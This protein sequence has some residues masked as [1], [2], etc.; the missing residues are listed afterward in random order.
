MQQ[1]DAGAA[2]GP[3]QAR[4]RRL[5]RIWF[6]GSTPPT[7]GGRRRRRRSQINCTYYR[8]LLLRPLLLLASDSNE[9]FRNEAIHQWARHPR[10]MCPS[11]WGRGGGGGR[12]RRR[13]RRRGGGWAAAAAGP[14]LEEEVAVGSLSQKTSMKDRDPRREPCHISKERAEVQFCW[15]LPRNRCSSDC[16]PM[17]S[18]SL[19]RI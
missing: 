5:S 8:Q 18:L 19:Y 14:E 4:Q 9:M 16:C 11:G 1:E 12:R 6:G 13:R 17:A 3:Q 10:H 7:A 2:R 15:S